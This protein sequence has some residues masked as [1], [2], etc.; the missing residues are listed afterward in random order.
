[1]AKD[2]HQIALVLF[3]EIVLIKAVLHGRRSRVGG[4][5]SI[6]QSTRELNGAKNFYLM[7][8][9]L[10]QVCVPTAKQQFST[11]LQVFTLHFGAATFF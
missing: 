1:M 4:G 11:L 7:R 3:M 6:S 2:L 5:G 9:F 8:V 10:P